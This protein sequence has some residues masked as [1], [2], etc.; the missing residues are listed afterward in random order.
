[1]WDVF[2]QAAGGSE[3]WWDQQELSK[4]SAASN[5]LTELSEKVALLPA[6]TVLDMHDNQIMVVP[7][8]ISECI[9]LRS[10]HL[11]RNQIAALP[12]EI[13]V[14]TEL[15]SLRLEQNLSVNPVLSISYT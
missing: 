9:A 8:A 13:C 6:L 14:L 15:Q 7:G 4:L 1:V 10:V 3:N 12:K 5:Q 2:L 11:G